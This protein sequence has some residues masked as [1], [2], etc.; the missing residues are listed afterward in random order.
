MYKKIL[1]GT[2]GSDTATIAVDRA[3]EVAKGTGAALTILSAGKLDRSQ[4]VVDAEAARLEGCGVTV[5]TAAVEGDA[6]AALVDHARDGGYDLV[7]LGNK[8]MTGVTRFF[9]LGSVTNKVSHHLPCAL[10]IVK[11]S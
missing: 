6:S 2:D 4:A 1:V 5:D 7:V 11:T 8:G 10:L 3:V 9:H